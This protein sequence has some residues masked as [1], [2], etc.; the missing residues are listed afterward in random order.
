MD[1]EQIHTKWGKFLFLNSRCNAK[2][3]GVG[4]FFLKKNNYVN[5]LSPC[6]THHI[7]LS[8][9]LYIGWKYYIWRD[10]EFDN[11]CPCPALLPSLKDIKIGY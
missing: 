3:D 2:Q 4:E 9:Y 1:F 8:F 6:P 10:G 7:K 11:V 5:Y